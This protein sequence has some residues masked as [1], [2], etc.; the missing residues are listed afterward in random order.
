[1]N[2][3][4]LSNKNLV[5]YSKQLDLAFGLAMKTYTRRFIKAALLEAGCPA[6]VTWTILNMVE[7][8]N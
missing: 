2:R 4:T 6:G 7:A 8:S 5:K 3:K 1:V